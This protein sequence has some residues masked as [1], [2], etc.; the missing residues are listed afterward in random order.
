MKKDR[1]PSDILFPIVKGISKN[2]MREL[3][4]ACRLLL[5]DR[6]ILCS[7]V[8][9]LTEHWRITVANTA[10][11]VRDMMVTWPC[12]SSTLDWPIKNFAS[13]MNGH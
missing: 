7:S 9:N 12:P 2:E 10:R 8:K 11:N 5:N 6:M 4:G 13:V 3:L 1:P